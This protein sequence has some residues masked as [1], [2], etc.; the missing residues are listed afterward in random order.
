MLSDEIIKKR[1]KD[2]VLVSLARAGT[3][4]G[5]LI[6]RYIKHK[7]NIDVPHYSISIIRDI[8]IDTNAL[9]YVV[10]EHPTAQLQF[11]DGWTGK[12]VIQN[13]LFDAC[14]KFYKDFNVKLNPDLAV[15]SDPAYS[16]T[17]YSTTR[18]FFNTKCLS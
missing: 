17:T 11:I 8:G 10:K 3:P 16:T 15:L 6:K 2:L 1:G 13:T 14:E 18:R 7:Y 9:N 12:G 4:I 5:I